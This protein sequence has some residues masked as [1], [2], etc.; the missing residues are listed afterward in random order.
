MPELQPFTRLCQ[1]TNRPRT[2]GR[3]DLHVHTTCSDGCYT[4]AEVVDLARRSG[5]AAVAITDHDTFDGIA[6]AEVAASGSGLEIVPGVEI[7]AEHDG[8]ELH[9]LGYYVCQDHR[10]LRA[11]LRR[12][13]E[14]RV[15]RYWDMVE[16]LRCFGVS[17]DEQA[18]RDQ[19][20]RGVL[21]RRHLAMLIVKAGKAGSLREAFQRFLGDNGRVVVP[22]LRLPVAEAI[23]LVRDTGGVTSWA[24]PS[25]RC[26]REKLQEL[27][28]V[29]LQAVEA[30]YPTF[31][32]KWV[33][34]LK[35]WADELGLAVTGG[36]DCHGP[37]R[38]LGRC[39]LTADELD[40]LRQLVTR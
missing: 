23:H 17:L 27:S 18:L 2:I 10:P 16:R 38:E 31:K 11:A 7:T 20:K 5:L 3:A 8:R 9:L 39:S 4:P 35:S 29:G 21:S 36:S 13:R 24:H 12:L 37:G 22:K 32:N 1:L 26:T 28:D 25:N 19:A 6:D 15:G 34:Q 40:D 14:H 33:R 30:Y